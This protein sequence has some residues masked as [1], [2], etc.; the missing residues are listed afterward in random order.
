MDWLNNTCSLNSDCNGNG[1][2]SCCVSILITDPEGWEEQA[3]RC[4]TAG[5]FEADVVQNHE[6]D[7]G[8]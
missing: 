8:T 4:Q 1:L 6:M 7:D 2:T 5:M 3:F